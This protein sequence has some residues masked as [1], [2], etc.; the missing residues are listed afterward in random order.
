MTRP[1]DPAE[2]F[3]NWASL[4][5][6]CLREARRHVSD[7]ADAQDVV[8]E[9]LLRGWRNLDRCRTP[10][11]PLPWLLAITRNEALRRRR[12]RDDGAPLDDAPDQVAGE[13]IHRAGAR[14]DI[15]RALGRLSAPERRLV[16]LRYIVDMTCADLAEYLGIPEVTVRVRLHRARRRLRALMAT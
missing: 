7:E 4:R 11:A 14:I 15:A 6:A 1:L 8:Q 2:T 13:E 9:A 3:H 12:R 16:G 10:D 5:Q